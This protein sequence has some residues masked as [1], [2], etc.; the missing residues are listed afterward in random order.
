MKLKIILLSVLLLGFA[1]IASQNFMKDTTQNCVAG[2][3]CCSG[4][5]GVCGCSSGRAQ[6]CDGTLSPSCK[7]FKDDI[8]PLE[9]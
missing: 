8:K 3:G 1:V 5:Q 7:C 2:R 9:M 4:H 6:C